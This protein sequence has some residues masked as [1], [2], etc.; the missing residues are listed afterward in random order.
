MFHFVPK[1]NLVNDCQAEYQRLDKIDEEQLAMEHI[2][3]PVDWP[4]FGHYFYFL[5]APTLLYRDVYPRTERVRRRF[6]LTNLAQVVASIFFGYL[7]LTTFIFPR[8]AE[9]FCLTWRSLLCHVFINSLP[10]LVVIMLAFFCFLHSWLNSWAEAMRFGDRLFYLD[11]WNGRTN[12]DYFRLWNVV[13][14]NWLYTY[15]YRDLQLILL[16]R[17]RLLAAAVVFL[18]SASIHEYVMAL[19]FGFC[20]PVMF[21]ILGFFNFFLFSLSQQGLQ[22]NLLYWLFLSILN[23]VTMMFYTM[24]WYAR[25]NSTS[26]M[27]SFW[28]PETMRCGYKSPQAGVTK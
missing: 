20:L 22:G 10:T 26:G 12:Q 1:P 15:V 23:S 6:L 3:A 28:F 18:L 4:S 14:H 25:V 5:F 16:R 8:F 7:V 17:Q 9:H 19:S 13:V 24:E 21:I 27:K 2:S 11:W